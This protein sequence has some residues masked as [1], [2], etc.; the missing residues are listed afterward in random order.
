L[1]RAIN[2]PLN[3]RLS[4]DEKPLDGNY[5]TCPRL[6]PT[7]GGAHVNPDRKSIGSNECNRTRP[8][9]GRGLLGILAML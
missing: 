9:S 3:R 8:V 1:A 6:L 7:T 4:S 5:C 2:S